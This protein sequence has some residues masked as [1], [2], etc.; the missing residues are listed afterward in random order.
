MSKQTEYPLEQKAYR[1]SLSL[2]DSLEAAA[3]GTLSVISCVALLWFLSGPQLGI[4]QKLMLVFIWAYIILMSAGIC[5]WK[6]TLTFVTSPEGITYSRQGLRIFTPWSNI[7]CISATTEKRFGR[8]FT[9]SGL[10]LG[11]PAPIYKPSLL[12]RWILIKVNGDPC[13]F[14][15]LRTPAEIKGPPIAI[16]SYSSS[17]REKDCS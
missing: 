11:Q 15:P 14:I 3:C 1:S 5:L 4:P 16:E 2:R 12:A 7:E 17:H 6:I 8:T 9:I 13:Y 10:K